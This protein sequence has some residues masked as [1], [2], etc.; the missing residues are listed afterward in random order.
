M[1]RRIRVEQEA[2]A[3]L[4]SS[5]EYYRGEGGEELALRFLAHTQEAFELL[6]REPGI[7]HV[8]GSA[9]AERLKSLR[10]WP[11]D[12]FPYVVF[13][14]ADAEELRVYCVVHGKRDIETLIKA[15]LS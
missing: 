9:K 13:Y 7:G 11:L 5:V 15:R 3:D 12:E 8:F 2:E 6:E 4:A 10:V 14:E 1:K